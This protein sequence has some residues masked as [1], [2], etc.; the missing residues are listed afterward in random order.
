MFKTLTSQMMNSHRLY[1]AWPRL[2]LTSWW[3]LSGASPDR[4][5][6]C[7]QLTSATLLAPGAFLQTIAGQ[8]NIQIAIFLSAQVP[9]TFQ[10]SVPAFVCC[11]FEAMENIG[12]AQDKREGFKQSRCNIRLLITEM[13][14]AKLGRATKNTG[15]IPNLGILYGIQFDLVHPNHFGL[16]LHFRLSHFLPVEMSTV[17]SEWT[18]LAS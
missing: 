5:S 4:V 9:P 14:G 15:V 10:V 1:L 6:D 3:L 16:W 11:S 12:S 7:L 17:L 18:Q 8:K 13:S 2:A